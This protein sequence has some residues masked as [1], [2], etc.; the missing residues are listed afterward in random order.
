MMGDFNVNGAQPDKYNV[1]KGIFE[2]V[3]AVDA[4]RKVRQIGEIDYTSNVWGNLL[5]QLFNPRK[6]PNSRPPDI[7][8][9]MF[10]KES[11][12]GLQ[13]TPVEA[14]VPRDWKYQANRGWWR[15]VWAGKWA[16]NYVAVVSFQL[17][18]HPHLFGLK[19]NNTAYISRINDDGKGWTDIYSGRWASNY[20]GTAIATFNLNGHPHI[21]AL[22]R[23]GRAYISRINDDG[24]GWTDIHDGKWAP[25]YVAVVS[26]ELN[27]HPYLFGLKGNNTA[28]ISRI[29]DDGKGWKDIYQGRWSSYY[30]GTAITPFYLDGHPYI[31][32]LKS[33]NT[34]YLSRINDDA[35]GWRD[36]HEGKWASTYVAVRSFQLDGHPYLFGLKTNNRA[37]ISRINDDGR[38][39]TDMYS[40]KWSSNY[41]G[42]AFTTFDL[43]V[44]GQDGSPV[45][46]PHMFSLKAPNTQGWITRFSDQTN[47]AMDLSDH[48]PV[49]VKF[50]VTRTNLSAR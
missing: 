1:M 32:A 35:R 6:G 50:R 16:A 10:V 49:W 42:T 13:L 17:N 2:Q 38:G 12:G 24:K 28:Y 30:V 33:N 46:L 26:F 39:W 18:G 25:N 9:Y 44:T 37:Y 31:F 19:G 14:G 29:N 20:V 41:V 43:Q 40:G 5:Y 8:D 45:T 36:V 15:D 7:L 27:G 4:Y 47:I 23:T 34:A 21:F 48:Y 11:G 3:G 22:K